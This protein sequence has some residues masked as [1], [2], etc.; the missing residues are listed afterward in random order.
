MSTGKIEVGDFGGRMTAKQAVLDA[1]NHL[2]DGDEK[3]VVVIKK[4]DGSYLTC[5]ST[6]DAETLLAMGVLIQGE[7]VATIRG[8]G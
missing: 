2:S 7:A 3:A 8:A 5:W 6:M 4:K 1:L